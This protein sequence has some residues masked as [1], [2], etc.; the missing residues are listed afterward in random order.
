M[1]HYNKRVER[2]RPEGHCSKRCQ[3]NMSMASE[4]SDIGGGG[5]CMRSASKNLQERCVEF[6]FVGAFA[7]QQEEFL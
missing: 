4:L 7:C 2:G 5:T 6:L 1:M 3:L